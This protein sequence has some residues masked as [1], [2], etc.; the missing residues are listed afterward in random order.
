MAE[1]KLVAKSP[2]G[3]LQKVWG[4]T[5]LREETNTAAV[6]ASIPLGGEDAFAAALLAGTGA[7]V[8]AVGDS[9]AVGDVRVVG[10]AE[11]QVMILYPGAPHGGVDT[12]RTYMGDAAYLV[13]QTNNWVMLHLDGPLARPALERMT[14]LNLLDTAYPLGRAERTV[15]EHMGALVVRTGA[16][17]FLLMSASSTAQSFAHAVEQS[18]DWVA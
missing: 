8:P 14:A 17:G 4:K 18:L 3:G 15:M 9:V 10:F 11:A 13:E 1:F 2:L 5:L 6:V 16:D 12:V 7:V